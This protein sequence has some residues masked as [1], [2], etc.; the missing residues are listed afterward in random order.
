VAQSCGFAN[1]K[2]I[3]K[4]IPAQT[5]FLSFAKVSHAIRLGVGDML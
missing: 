3:T 4:G 1:I 5:A 2:I